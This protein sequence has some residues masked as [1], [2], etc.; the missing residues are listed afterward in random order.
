MT[1]KMPPEATRFQ[2]R[3]ASTAVRG[4]C[5]IVTSLPVGTGGA[6]ERTAYWES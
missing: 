2:L 5:T 1:P 3:V 6:L 4:T